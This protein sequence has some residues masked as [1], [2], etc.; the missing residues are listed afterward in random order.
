MA[1]PWMKLTNITAANGIHP[2]SLLMAI[3]GVA[4]MAQNHVLTANAP[5][6]W[7]F[8][9]FTHLMLVEPHSQAVRM[10]GSRWKR[11]S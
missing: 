4:Q 5:H 3:I 6:R 9:R 8:G 7:T 11:E 2:E 1:T 10:P